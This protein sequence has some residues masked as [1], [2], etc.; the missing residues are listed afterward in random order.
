MPLLQGRTA[1]ITGAGQGSGRA[2]AIL[3]ASEGAEIVIAERD[4]ATGAAVAAEVEAA[5]GRALFVHT[6]I[7]Q[8]DQVEALI[9]RTFETFGKIDVLYNNAGGSTTA[10]GPVTTAPLEEFWRTINV[11][12]YG[13]FLCSRFALP[14]M[15][16]AK[17]GA[18]VNTSSMVALIGRKNAHSY[19][20]SKGAVT[21]LTRAMAAEYG[22]HNIRVNAVAPGVTRSERVEQRLAAGRIQQYVL[23]RHVLGLPEPIDVARTALY[24]AS[25]L[26]SRV[27]G[28]IVPVDSGMT[29]F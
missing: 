16:A 1:I 6:D 12:L 29:A 18:V 21:A 28:Q 24:L 11:D 3:F 26:S 10:D 13:T 4:A 25:D 19:T 2:A 17:R 8:P 23:D 22:E 27:T 7:T 9:G 20:A 5:G 14:H 15:I